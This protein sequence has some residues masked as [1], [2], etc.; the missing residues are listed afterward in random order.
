MEDNYF[1]ILWWSLPY[2]N[3]N[4]PQ[5]YMCPSP[6]W[7]PPLTSLPTLS[8]WVVPEHWLW[9]PWEAGILNHWTYKGGPP[10]I[11]RS[12]KFCACHVPSCNLLSSSTTPS[13]FPCSQPTPGCFSESLLQLLWAEVKMR[14]QDLWSPSFSF[15]S[16]PLKLGVSAQSR[17]TQNQD[18]PA[19]KCQRT[20]LI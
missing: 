5:V 19:L 15:S 18:L 2:I 11:E 13:L 16:V 9:V 12:F 20:W 10:A 6:S 7:T 14:S 1:T 17:E 3:V 4:W 8:L